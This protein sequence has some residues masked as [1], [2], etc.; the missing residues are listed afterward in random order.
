LVL[1]EVILTG[2]VFAIASKVG[3]EQVAWL[4]PSRWGYALAASTSNL[5]TI[6]PPTPGNPSTTCGT[7]PG[8]SG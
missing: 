3:L 8:T 4:S 6:F 7:T 5:N 2:G 1:V